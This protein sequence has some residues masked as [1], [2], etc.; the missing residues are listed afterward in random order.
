MQSWLNT[1]KDALIRAIVLRGIFTLCAVGAAGIF[2]GAAIAHTTTGTWPVP[3]SLVYIVGASAILGAA[4]SYLVIAMSIHRAMAN[5]LRMLELASDAKRW[6]TDI[7][8]RIFPSPR[9]GRKTTP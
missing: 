7:A 8:F 1:Q 3:N 9:S 5:L 2:A 4:A 6:I